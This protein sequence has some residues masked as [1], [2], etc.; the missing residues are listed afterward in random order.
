LKTGFACV[1]GV[2]EDPGDDPGGG[3]GEHGLEE[4]KKGG[5]RD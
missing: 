5:G 4:L 1:E 2:A 3:T